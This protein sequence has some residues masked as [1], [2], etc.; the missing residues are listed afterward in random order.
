MG[1]EGGGGAEQGREQQRERGWVGER[2]A[3]RDTNRGR[4]KPDLQIP[5]WSSHDITLT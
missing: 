2:K 4:R 1:R 3:G 5:N